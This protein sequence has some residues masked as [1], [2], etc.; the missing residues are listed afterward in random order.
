M[1]FYGK[2]AGLDISGYDVTLVGKPWHMRHLDIETIYKD[3]TLFDSDTDTLLGVGLTTILDMKTLPPKGSN[4]YIAPNCPLAMDDI[5]N[6]YTIK[7]KP[8]TGDYNVF[9]SINT[10]RI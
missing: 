9:S 8:D 10:R 4:V 7:K 6:N 2:I 5:R 1:K 3:Y